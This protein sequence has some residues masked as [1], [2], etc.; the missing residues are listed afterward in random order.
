MHGITYVRLW[1]MMKTGSYYINVRKLESFGRRV[2]PSL[3]CMVEV[4]QS[5]SEYRR[6]KP[7]RS[8]GSA[9]KAASDFQRRKPNKSL[10]TDACFAGAG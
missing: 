2:S 4:P 5:F 8:L 10:N 6:K 7:R 1:S 9:H 3:K